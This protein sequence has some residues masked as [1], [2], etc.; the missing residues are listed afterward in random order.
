MLIFINQ[1]LTTTPA[2]GSHIV[3]ALLARGEK[4]I[5]VF[6]AAPSPL[7]EEEGRKVMSPLLVVV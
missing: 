1:F 7:F 4:D 3:E 5:W 6:D 2:L